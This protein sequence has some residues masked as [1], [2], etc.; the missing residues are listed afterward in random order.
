MEFPKLELIWTGLDW[1]DWEAEWFSYTT[2]IPSILKT[3]GG[4]AY[5]GHHPMAYPRADASEMEKA[6]YANK[7]HG[8]AFDEDN[9]KYFVVLQSKVSNTPKAEWIRDFKATHDGHDAIMKL[10]EVPKGRL[11]SDVG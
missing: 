4:I 11:P 3:K 1:H 5:V 7:L 8:L 9:Q 10:C 6:T 2:C